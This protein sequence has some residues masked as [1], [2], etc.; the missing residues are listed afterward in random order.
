[1]K[2]FVC[3]IEEAVISATPRD[4]VT[5]SPAT[6]QAIHHPLR[7]KRRR[8]EQESGGVSTDEATL[9][10]V[11]RGP[12]RPDGFLFVPV[13]GGSGTGKSHLVRWAR[14][15]LEGT[16]N[17]E[18]RYLPKNGTSIRRV[19]EE[20]ITGMDGPVADQARKDLE[21]ATPA[22]ESR[23]VLADRLLDELAILIGLLTS[24]EG[25]GRSLDE[26]HFVEHK[27]HQ[28]S[29]IL[30][31]PVVRR[32]L[33]RDG[34]VVPRLVD[35]AIAGRTPGDGLDDDAVY[36]AADDLPGAERELAAAGKEVQAFLG[37]LQSIHLE[38]DRPGR[39]SP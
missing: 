28:L 38:P 14:E 33:R 24:H 9:L 37:K 25:D 4:A 19:I 29:D 32:R 5:L 11:M 1:V 35:L 26:A 23:E 10:D 13:V 34:A 6:F 36:V 18:I 20:V 3:W 39:R 8:M 12:L 21:A 16:E 22:N 2:N 31:D 7:L 15:N 27:R 17:W 30:R